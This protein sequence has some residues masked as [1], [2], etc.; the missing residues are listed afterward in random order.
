MRTRCKGGAWDGLP[1]DY[2]K[3]IIWLPTKIGWP[4]YVQVYVFYIYQDGYYV[5]GARR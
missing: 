1:I 2:T 5:G 3:P 4:D